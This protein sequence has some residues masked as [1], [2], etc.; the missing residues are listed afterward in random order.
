M[1]FVGCYIELGFFMTDNNYLYGRD[2]TNSETLHFPEKL[3]YF[4]NFRFVSPSPLL[5]KLHIT[6]PHQATNPLTSV[7]TA[8]LITRA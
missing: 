7:N 8:V 1:V 4:S 2:R 6:T 5:S 3:T